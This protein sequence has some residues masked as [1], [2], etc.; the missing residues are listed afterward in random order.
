M[1]LEK[2]GENL[3]A[4]LQKLTGSTV[5]DEKL[6]KEVVKDIQ[7]ALL[8]ADVNVQLVFDITGTI[9]ER[10]LSKEKPAGISRQ[11]HIVKIV[12]EELVSFL[13]E[14]TDVEP[15]S[16]P[17]T[18]MLVGLFGA[19]KTTSAGKLAS[20]YKTRNHTVAVVQTD[21]WRPAA[22]DQLEQLAGRAGV[23]FYGDE[24]AETP[25][26][27]YEKYEDTLAQYDVVIVDTAGRD[28]LND[29]LVAEIESLDATVD[30]DA[31]WLVLSADMGQGAQQQAETFQDSVDVDGVMITKL[32][33]TAKGGGALTACAVTG[34]PITFIGV[35]EKLD[36]LE[37][38]RPEGFVGRLLGMGDI[39]TLLEKAQTA[40]DEE[41]A[42][43][44]GKRFLQGKFNL[45][46]LY[47][48]ME[49][50]NQ[51]GS[52]GKIMEMVPGFSNMDLPKQAIDVQEEK[53]V[54]WR[55]LMDSMT[56]EELENPDIINASRIQ[57]IADGAAME[58]KSVR[59]LLKQYNQ[60]KK[61]AK[62]F[63][64]GGNK[65]MKEMMK[66]MQQGGG[67]NLPF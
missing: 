65:K 55:I 1:V 9:K 57:R 14:R 58:A 42:E 31:S 4:T 22:Y 51:M 66:K 54:E 47:E 50:V 24:D 43:D 3:K 26:A 32:D 60:A 33:G 35:G 19:G 59:G 45:L 20:Y 12:Y 39:E 27:I 8:Q 15:K 63:K 28:A 10:A 56:R 61:M 67:G 53:M 25:D 49:A 13:G 17:F 30:P 18:I 6:V 36:D 29:E 40:I 62:M 46:D 44:L 7:R 2:L 21:T 23:D 64:G 41:K 11:E 38:F 34:A 5:I 16:K 52:L 48:Q 37:H